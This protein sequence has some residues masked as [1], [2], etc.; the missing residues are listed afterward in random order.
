[1]IDEA[2]RLLELFDEVQS[3]LDRNPTLRVVLTGSSAR[4]LRGSGINLL[5]RRI[6]RRDLSPLVFP[7]TGSGR[8]ADGLV[9]G[10]LPAILDSAL[11]KDDPR[12]YVG[13]YKKTCH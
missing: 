5:S 8:I 9:R 13:L 7:E 6:W 11:F 2:Q 12:N 3:I 4:K 10:P 1:L